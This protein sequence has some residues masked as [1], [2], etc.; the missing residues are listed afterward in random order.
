MTDDD[1][2]RLIATGIVGTV[3]AALGGLDYVLLSALAVL[4]ALTV[5][6][7]WREQRRLNTQRDG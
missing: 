6:A 7:V 1:Q 4:V 2:R 5:Y 3:V